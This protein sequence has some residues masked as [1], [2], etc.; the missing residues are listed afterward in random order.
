M[1]HGTA[2]PGSL[3]R[4]WNRSAFGLE[5]HASGSILRISVSERLDVPPPHVHT[6]GPR[7][8]LPASHG[9]FRT[10][11][12]PPCV[13]GVSSSTPQERE[14]HSLWFG[15]F[16][17]NR[18]FFSQESPKSRETLCLL[19]ASTCSEPQGR[20]PAECGGDGGCPQTRDVA[21]AQIKRHSHTFVHKRYIFN[22]NVQ[23][24]IVLVKGLEFL[25]EL[26]AV[27]DPLSGGCTHR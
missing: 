16:K 26:R 21:C 17:R 9:G 27:R 11:W 25:R 22:K 7:C 15:G 8:L 6:P 4:C 14:P 13:R 19:P 12:S 5:I 1:T 10:H 24:G 23:W 20:A 2:L 3:A 18:I